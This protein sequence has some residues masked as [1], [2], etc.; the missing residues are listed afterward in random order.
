MLPRVRIEDSCVMHGNDGV[1]GQ[2]DMMK[3]EQDL[4]ERETNIDEIIRTRG[5][6]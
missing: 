3:S 2:V 4:A 6:Y 5:K 1:Y